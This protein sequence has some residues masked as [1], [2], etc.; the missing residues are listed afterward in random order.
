M[1]SRS[2]NRQVT[3]Q[4]RAAGEDANGQPNGAWGTH[5]VLWANVRHLNGIETVRSSAESSKVSASIR[6]GYR[7]DLTTA[8]RALDGSTVFEIK[9]VLP[10]R[11]GK[12]HVDLACELLS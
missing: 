3:I 12:K 7:T 2:R 11:V 4:T 5:A 1:D 10:D 8:M 9:A 6:V